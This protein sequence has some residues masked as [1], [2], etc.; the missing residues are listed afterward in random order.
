MLKLPSIQHE[1]AEILDNHL[2]EAPGT[3]WDPLKTTLH[4]AAL[5]VL[6]PDT[7]NHL[8]WFDENDAEIQTLLEEKRQLHQA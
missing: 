4:S 1:L 7:R 3:D 6:G 5:K 2:K 8:D